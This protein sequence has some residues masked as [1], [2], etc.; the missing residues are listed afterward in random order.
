MAESPGFKIGRLTVDRESVR[1][2]KRQDISPAM[3][4]ADSDFQMKRLD[5]PRTPNLSNVRIKLQ[6]PN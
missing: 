2:T 6:D 4:G 3:S 5:F 1:E